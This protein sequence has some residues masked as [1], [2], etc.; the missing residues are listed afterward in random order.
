MMQFCWASDSLHL[1][2]FSSL[3][4]YPTCCVCVWTITV[5]LICRVVPY[6]L[7]CG[8]APCARRQTLWAFPR[9]S[10]TSWCVSGLAST[11][12]SNGSRRS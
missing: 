6:L 5:A 7:P 10:S 3:T 2:V 8:H 1:L 11:Q 4:V 9:H 12:S